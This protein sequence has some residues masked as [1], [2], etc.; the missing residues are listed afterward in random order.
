MSSYTKPQSARVGWCEKVCYQCGSFNIQLINLIDFLAGCMFLIFAIYLYTKFDDGNVNGE[1]AW[2]VWCSGLL[3]VLLLLTTFFSFAAI[4]NRGCRCLMWMSCQL[5]LVL[6]ALDLGAGISAIV[7]QKRFYSYL[8][9]HGTENGIT[10]TDIQDIKNWY[11]VI[12]CMMLGSCILEIVRFMLSRGFKD[13]SQRIDGE[14]GAL[15]DQEDQEWQTKL[16]SNNEARSEKYRDLRSHYK[17]KYAAFK[18]PSDDITD[19]L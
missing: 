15:I 17:E 1:S 5:A 9:E 2:M 16:R 3:G 14:F 7:L 18:K 6:S 4:T 13:T 12:A 10:E 19:L 11:L 8:D